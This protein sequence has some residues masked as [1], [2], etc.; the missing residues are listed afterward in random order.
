MPLDDAMLTV[1]GPVDDPRIALHLGHV[2]QRGFAPL[3]HD[4]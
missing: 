3:L 2:R 4:S 1:F